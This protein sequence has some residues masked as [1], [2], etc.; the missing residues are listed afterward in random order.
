M[1]V[2]VIA[3]LKPTAC[4]AQGK[5]CSVSRTFIDLCHFVFEFLYLG[6]CLNVCMVCGTIS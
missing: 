1:F 5:I 2:I 4:A 6:V 3:E